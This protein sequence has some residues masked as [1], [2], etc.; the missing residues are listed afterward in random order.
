MTII[1]AMEKVPRPIARKLN[2]GGMNST[3]TVEEGP[4]KRINAI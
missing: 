2:H 1:S 4:L 3:F